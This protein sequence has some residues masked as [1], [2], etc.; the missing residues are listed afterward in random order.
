MTLDFEIMF[1]LAAAKFL[2]SN[3]AVESGVE[4]FS[5]ILF[6]IE[7]FRDTLA[8]SFVLLSDYDN[9]NAGRPT[10]S[11]KKIVEEK[12]LLKSCRDQLTWLT[13]R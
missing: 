2:S 7:G 12:V 5:L 8:L 13:V 4:W 1:V 9:F 11:E 10:S 3:Y 6:F